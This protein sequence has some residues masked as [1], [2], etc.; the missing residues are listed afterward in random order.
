LLQSPIKDEQQEEQNLIFI[1]TNGSAD[2]Q[3]PLQDPGF[4]NFINLSNIV[5]EAPEN[6]Y[7]L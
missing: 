6:N 3:D 2:K 7:D 5:P 4:E 1:E